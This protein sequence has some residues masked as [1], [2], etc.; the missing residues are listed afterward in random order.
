MVVISTREFRTNQTHYLNLAKSGER[1]ILK[2]R[3]GCF[4]I[5]PEKDDNGLADMPRN[6]A[7]EL[8]DALKEAKDAIAGKC[9]LQS[10]ENL[11]A[12]L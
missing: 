12:N 9:K 11:L 2:S 7:V 8:K 3:V 10:A 6:L 1:V 5:F 4:R